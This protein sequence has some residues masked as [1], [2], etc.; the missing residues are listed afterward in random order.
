MGRGSS[1]AGSGSVSISGLKDNTDFNAFIRENMSNKAFR[2]FGQNNDM[3]D[4]K[5]L[6]YQERMRAEAANIHEISAEEAIDTIRDNV[7]ASYLDGWFRS[8]DYGY[9]DGIAEAIVSNPGT[10]NA[11]LNIAYKNYVDSLPD[12]S[13]AAS[14]QKWARTPQTVYRGDSGRN[15]NTSDVFTSFTPDRAVAADFARRSNGSVHSTKIRPIDTFGSFQTTG[16]QEFLVPV[17]IRKR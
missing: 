13:K 4:V 2:E 14:F 3:D 15:Y 1:K 17:K 16:E 12:Q 11:G 10:L 7:P 8:A 6:W 5:M 9:K